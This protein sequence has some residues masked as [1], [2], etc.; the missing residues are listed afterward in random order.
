MYFGFMALF[1][2]VSRGMA[3][4]DFYNAKL[5]SPRSS[6]AHSYCRAPSSSQVCFAMGI[7]RTQWLGGIAGWIGFTLPS[8]LLMFGFA[9]AVTALSGRF[10]STLIHG[11]QLVA[12][13]IVAHAA[14]DDAAFP[15]AGSA[16]NRALYTCPIRHSDR[17]HCRSHLRSC[18]VPFHDSVCASSSA[19]LCLL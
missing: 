17:Y 18:H 8:V 9:F 7:V 15:C 4:D 16:A 19:Y 2:R 12:V 3:H 1:D 14:N 5:A 11:L 6:L 13:T 10:G